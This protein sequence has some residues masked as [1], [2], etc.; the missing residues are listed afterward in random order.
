M[1]HALGLLVVS[2]AGTLTYSGL[3]YDKQYVNE[4][5]LESIRRCTR[6]TMTRDQW[7]GMRCLY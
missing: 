6:L 7:A 1:R 4:Q 3:S 2:G 5:I